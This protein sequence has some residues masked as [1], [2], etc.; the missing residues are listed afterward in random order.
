MMSWPPEISS[1][2]V[3]SAVERVAALVDVGELD[4]SRRSR[5]VPASG[6]SWPVIMRNRVVLPAPLGPMTPTMPPGGRLKVRSSM[7][8]LSP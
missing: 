4:A 7:S 3:L 2:T 5:S 6:F 1:Q 8:S